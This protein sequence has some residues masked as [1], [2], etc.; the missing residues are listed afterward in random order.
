MARAQ[1]RRFVKL[2]R[3]WVQDRRGAIA[4]TTG[5]MIMPLALATGLAIDTS[6]MFLVRSHLAEAVDAAALAAGQAIDLDSVKA[7]AKRIFKL[8]YPAPYL[9]ATVD[10]ADTNAFDV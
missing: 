4:A 7:D 2:V 8:N 6:R 5:L 1:R 10:V 3:R 9:G